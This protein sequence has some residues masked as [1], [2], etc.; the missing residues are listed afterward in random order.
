MSTHTLVGVSE[1]LGV[2]HQ[3]VRRY[4]QEGKLDCTYA[5]KSDLARHGA[6]LVS[7]EQL[8]AFLEPQRDAALAEAKEWDAKIKAAA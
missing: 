3:T 4:V 7:T 5:L 6:I 2:S 8:V 1:I